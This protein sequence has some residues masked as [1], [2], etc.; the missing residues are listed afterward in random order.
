[1]Y[2]CDLIILPAGGPGKASHFFCKFNTFVS[3]KYRPGTLFM[4]FFNPVIFY[5]VSLYMAYVCSGCESRYETPR[6][7][8]F[9]QKNCD[10]F[11]D[12]DTSSNTILNAFELYEKKQAQKKRKRETI[13]RLATATEV[14]SI[15]ITFGRFR[16]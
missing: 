8:E 10:S 1:M 9:H 15:I 16:L 2:S 14:R 13:A 4:R 7:L 11:L 3:P 12:V 5:L 6:G